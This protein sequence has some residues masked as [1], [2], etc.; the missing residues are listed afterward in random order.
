MNMKLLKGCVAG[1]VMLGTVAQAQ[2]TITAQSRM[3]SEKGGARSTIKAKAIRITAIIRMK[4]SMARTGCIL[5]GISTSV[6]L[7]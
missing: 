2:E 4:V 3:N 7:P 5:P 1:G 6:S